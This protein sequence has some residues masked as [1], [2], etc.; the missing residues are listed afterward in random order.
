MLSESGNKVAA[1]LTS[2]AAASKSQASDQGRHFAIYCDES[3][4]HGTRLMGFGS[5][6]MVWERR[7]DFQQLWRDLH[8]AHFPPS[9]VKWTKITKQT[10]PFFLALIDEF[11][12]R[13][14]LMFHCLVLGKSEIDLT[15]H[16]GDWDLARR[17]HFTL[18]LANKI[19]R[20]AAPGKVYRIR[21]DPIHSRYQKADEAAEVILR[22]LMEQAPRLSGQRVIHSL[23]T[24]E[25]KDSPGVQLGDVLLGAVMAARHGDVTA[26]PKL[27]VIERIAGHLGWD[28]LGADT[29]PKATK[30]NVWR[31]WDPTSG[32][33]RPEVTRRPTRPR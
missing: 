2:T 31:F 9:E 5:L 14:W 30:F 17:K 4:V 23:R 13:N 11:F 24:V 25:S 21:V 27:A 26:V 1:G 10:L 19:K 33:Q 20:F 7:G 22:N 28:D 3:G 12:A 18:L 32:T 29:F 8:A 16:D 15:L 6:W